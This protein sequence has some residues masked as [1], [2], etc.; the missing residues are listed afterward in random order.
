[1]IREAPAHPV[2]VKRLAHTAIESVRRRGS[3]AIWSSRAVASAA[4]TLNIKQGGMKPLTNLART[5][6]VSAGVSGNRTLSRLDDAARAGNRAVAGPRPPGGV[7]LLWDVRLDHHV[8]LIESEGLPDDH[9]DPAML[10]PVARSGLKEAF[11]T[12]KRAQGLLRREMSLG[13]E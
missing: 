2:F 7:P 13:I 12:I 6:A 4:G 8:R 10:S 11:R 5:Y 3:S 9:V 1:M